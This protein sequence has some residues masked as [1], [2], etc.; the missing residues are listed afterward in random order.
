MKRAII[1]GSGGQD[2]HY[3]FEHLTATGA[4]V[5]GITRQAIRVGG[6]LPAL[7]GV[8][9]LQDAGQIQDVIAAVVP[10]EVYYLAAFHHSAEDKSALGGV[11]LF[12]KSYE[13]HVLGLVH[14]LEAIRQSAPQA[15][16]FYAASSHVFGHSPPAPQTEATPLDPQCIYGITKVGG[17]Q[18]CR[19]YRDTHGIHASVGILYNHESARRRPDFLTK[20]IVRAAV[21]ISRG[22]QSRLTLGDLSAKVDWGYAPD[23]VDAMVRIVAQPRPD[24]YIIA[25]GHLHTVAEF[26]SIAFACVGLDWKQYVDEQPG[27]VVKNTAAVRVGDSSK[28]RGA[29]GWK[30]T[31]TFE[32]MIGVLVDAERHIG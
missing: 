18:C 21:A 10:D 32:Q 25:T 4:A 22:E 29:T 11:T 30:P 13:T 1:V 3:L 7:P 6:S 14:V 15:R 23:F 17:I 16:L 12:Q 8:I 5:L 28:L 24:E 31:V 2:G 19:F 20:K 26:V 9:D 27:I